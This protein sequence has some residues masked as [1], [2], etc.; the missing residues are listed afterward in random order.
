MLRAPYLKNVDVGQHYRICEISITSLITSRLICRLPR[1]ATSGL[2]CP[3][4]EGIRR[5]SRFE[6]AAAECTRAGFGHEFSHRE[7]LF[8]GFHRTPAPAIT[9][10]LVTPNFYS[11]GKLNHS[12]FGAESLSRKLVKAR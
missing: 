10:T 12:A 5:R 2:Q 7:Q 6:C 9:T 3:A 4:P 8:T 11:I 1:A